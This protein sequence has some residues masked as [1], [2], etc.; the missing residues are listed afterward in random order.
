MLFGIY[1]HPSTHQ[2]TYYTYWLP[3]V[4]NIRDTPQGRPTETL[5]SWKENHP[6]AFIL[7]SVLQNDI[8]PC[9]DI[10][11]QQWSVSEQNPKHKTSGF[12]VCIQLSGTS[13]CSYCCSLT[14]DT[15]TGINPLLDLLTVQIVLCN[16]LFSFLSWQGKLTS[17]VTS[18]LIV[19][20]TDFYGYVQAHSTHCK[21]NVNWDR[22]EMCL[23]HPRSILWQ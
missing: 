7:K 9:Q 13:F 14:Y 8:I 19:A 1:K 2:I 16:T 12:S 20:S 18:D 6:Q 4:L 15:H 3:K 17:Y 5:N 10:P 22:V 23:H 11:V 21:G